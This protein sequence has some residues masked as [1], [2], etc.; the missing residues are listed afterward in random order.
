MGL[1]AGPPAHALFESPTQQTV[2]KLASALPR[3]QSLVK[4]V[5]EIERL[6][7]KIPANYEDDAYVLR[8]GRSVLLPLAAP[9]GEAAV[10][11]GGDAAALS[12]SFGEHLAG[13][14]EACKQK[15][16][17]RE[18]VELQVH[19]NRKDEAI[20]LLQLPP[21]ARHTYALRSHPPHPSRRSR[22]R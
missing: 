3:V 12:A 13:L 19:L 22:S 1:A 5:T 10:K 4:E 11:I 16:A 15:D 9:M 14:D 17:A 18:L 7:A 8:F 21:P 20:L 2:Q 6:R